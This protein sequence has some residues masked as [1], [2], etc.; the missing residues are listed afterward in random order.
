MAVKKFDKVF[1]RNAT[2]PITTIAFAGSTPSGW[3]A[4]PAGALVDMAKID[5]DKDV[6]T[7]L[8]DGSSFV[9]SDKGSLEL[10]FIDF[11]HTDYS[12]IRSALLNKLVDVL[13]IDGENKAPGYCIWAVRLYPKLSSGE[14]EP[15]ITL[16]GE[17]KR[18][19]S[20][21]NAPVTLIPVT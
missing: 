8:N 15:K 7:E 13:L 10:S 4:L 21:S 9:G 12:A 2:T 3:T 11:A 1:Y 17:K 20:A 6:T 16:S 14:G 19:S 5:L 18:S